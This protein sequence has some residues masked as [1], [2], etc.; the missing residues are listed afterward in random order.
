MH[1]F[2]LILPIT[3]LLT[4]LSTTNGLSQ[5]NDGQH[6][7]ILADDGNVVCGDKADVERNRRRE[8]KLR[9]YRLKIH[10]ES[11]ETS[12]SSKDQRLAQ[13]VGTSGN[14]RNESGVNRHR[15]K[16]RSLYSSYGQS[17]SLRGGYVFASNRE[18]VDGSPS[19]GIFGAAYIK[20]IKR[21]GN[22]VLSLETEIVYSRDA[23]SVT[24][25]GADVT[26]KIWSVTGL[27]EGRYEYVTGWGFNPF[28][29]FGI[30]PAYARSALT[31][32]G[33]ENREGALVLAYSGRAGLQ[34]NI[35]EKISIEGGYRFLGST[36]GDSSIIQ[37]LE[38]GVNLQF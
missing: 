28:A 32:A 10:S 27:L 33:A 13:N 38:V 12:F 17:V 37:S 23:D 9:S 6:N 36:F 35:S 16:P 5:Q 11:I 21:Y 18:G 31:T 14:D 20:P 2:K 4:G 24:I 22:H 7:C 26:S 1:N 30:G 25:L 29:T 19:A 3:L 8:E 15:T 34:A